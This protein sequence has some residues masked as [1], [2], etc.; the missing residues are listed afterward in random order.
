MLSD[1]TLE[2]PDRRAAGLDATLWTVL[3]LTAAGLRLA[4]LAAAPLNGREAEQALAAFQAA[5]GTVSDAAAHISPLLFHLNTLLFFI[6]DG[7]EAMARLIP[8]LAGVGLTLT[9][10][11]LRRYLGRWGALGT[12]LLLA[13]SPSALFASRTLDGTMPA[14]LGVMVLVG[15]AAAFLDRWRLGLVTAGALGLAVALTAGAAGW[16]L[17]LGLLIALGIGLWMWREQVGWLWPLLRPA[18]GRGAA[19][20]GLGVLALGSGLGLHPAGLAA[21]GEQLLDWLARFRA[22]ATP[23]VAPLPILLAYEPLI[24]V[25]GLAGAVVA[26]RRQHTAGLL[27]AFWAAIGALQVALMPSRQP[28]DL[29]WLLLPLAGLAGLAIEALV[30]S[31]LTHGRWLNEG[32]YLPISLILWAHGGLALAHYAHSDDPV[33]LILAGLTILLQ[34][35]LLAAFGFAV[36]VP[37]VEESMEWLLQQG[38]GVMLRAGTLSLAAVLLAITIST[39]WGLAYLRPSDPRE[40]PVADPIAGEVRTLSQVA[41]QVSAQ[42]AAMETG[43]PVT[44]LGQPDPTVAW[45]LRHFE[46]RVVER[47][48]DE[49]P[50][51]VIAPAESALP[52]GYVGETFPLRRVWHPDWSGRATMLWWLYR[53]TSA[54]AISGQIVLWVRDDLPPVLTTDDRPPTTP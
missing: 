50:P 42:A 43:L 48:G 26:S 47:L 38:S 41:R 18:L 9:P 25:F 35:V 4:A 16:G 27:L 34:L 39:G 24:L 51:L 12:G 13:L 45:T 22:P 7:G 19:M 10:L 14:A 36:T 3:A 31:L 8:A 49:T 2:R 23:A 21:V 5:Q 15:C 54:P 11:F 29:L 46:Q 1:Q 52:A 28:A 40:L 53:E 20:T 44:F 6:G 37:T 30:N 32:L 17:L 33:S